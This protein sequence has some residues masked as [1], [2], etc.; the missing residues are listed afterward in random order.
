MV[1]VID[2]APRLMSRRSNISY[3]QID[4][5]FRR[6]ALNNQLSNIPSEKFQLEEEL[7]EESTPANFQPSRASSS[8]RL[9]IDPSKLSI[10]IPTLRDNVAK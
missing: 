2:H 6:H 3:N 1:A 4:V 5:R 7:A 9:Q 8:R 10:K